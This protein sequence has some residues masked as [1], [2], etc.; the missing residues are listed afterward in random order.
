MNATLPT[1]FCCNEPIRDDN[2]GKKYAATFWGK[3]Q[4]V[5]VDCAEGISEG[6]HI[7]AH[8]NVHGETMQPTRK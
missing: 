5:C 4:R 6:L 1:C 2:G 8:E 3:R 7:L